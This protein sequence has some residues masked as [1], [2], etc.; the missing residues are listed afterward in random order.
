MEEFDYPAVED[1]L[2]S[3]IQ[4]REKRVEEI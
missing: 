3:W 4:N 1:Q 2:F